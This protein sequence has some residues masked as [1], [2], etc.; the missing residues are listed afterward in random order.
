M[1]DAQVQDVDH[2]RME[3]EGSLLESVRDTLVETR[4]P[5]SYPTYRGE[6]TVHTR[7]TT[8]EKSL[9]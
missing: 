6:P 8:V 4:V 9:E 5:L 1:N 3:S 7:Q 2:R